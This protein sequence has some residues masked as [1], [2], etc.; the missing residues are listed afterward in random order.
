MKNIIFVLVVALSWVACNN[1]PTSQV[2]SQNEGAV[3]NDGRPSKVYKIT[4]QTMGTTYNITSDLSN[5]NQVKK[6]IDQL[7][8]EINHEVSTYEEDSYISM[9]N[10]SKENVVLQNTRNYENEYRHFKRNYNV[11]REVY[12]KS[13]GAFDPTVLPLV[14]Y[15][16]FG[17]NKKNPDQIDKATLEAIR[18]DVGFVKID[19]LMIS[20]NRKQYLVKQ[21]PGVQLDFSA[22]AKGYAVDE[23]AMLLEKAGSNN[24]LVEIG[25]EVRVKGTSDKADFWILGINKPEIGADINSVFRKMQLTDIAMAS[26]GNYRNYFKIGEQIYS[27][28][29]NPRTGYPERNTLLSATILAKECIIADAYATA[30]MVLGVEEARILIDQV[31]GVEA[32][33]IYSNEK[34][35]LSEL[36]T[37]GASYYLVD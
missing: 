26:S 21:Q 5:L 1:T 17:P 10:K 22:L 4:G 29:I 31:D 7:L 3:S 11:A 12:D 18:A 36:Q 13:R 33:F 20:E 34:G 27:H 32:Y 24:Y 28:T 6:D 23:V 35:E 25:G 15:W 16:G 37:N 9:F 14:N 19:K 2:S 8:I 30:C